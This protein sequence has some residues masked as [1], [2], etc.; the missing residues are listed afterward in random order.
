MCGVVIYCMDRIQTQRVD[1]AVLD[2]VQ[3]ILDEKA[4]Y[5]VAERSVEVNCVAP[6]RR[7]AVCKVRAK[8][9]EIIPFRPKVVIDDIEDQR[10]APPMAFVCQTPK[11][12]RIT[13]AV[14]Y[15]ERIHPIVSPVAVSRKL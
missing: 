9:A 3:C 8:I 14:M 10:H 6:R 13:I 15:R 5:V 2:P 7:I 1:A 4:P 11:S 12:I